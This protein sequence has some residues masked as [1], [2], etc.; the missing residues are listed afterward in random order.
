MK[1]HFK[2]IQFFR[3]FRLLYLFLF[4][5]VLNEPVFSDYIFCT[6]STVTPL[7]EKE[8]QEMKRT[9]IYQ[10]DSTQQL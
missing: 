4:T 9:H 10:F 8:I 1:I 2:F 7:M 6:L 5:G 3:Y